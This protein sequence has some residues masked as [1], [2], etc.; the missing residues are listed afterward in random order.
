MASC[1]RWQKGSGRGLQDPD[2][3]VGHRVDE[4]DD[5]AVVLAPLFSVIAHVARVGDAHGDGE[6]E[7]GAIGAG[8]FHEISP[9]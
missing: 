5:P 4:A 6:G 2:G 1:W 8:L 7:V 9:R 3:N